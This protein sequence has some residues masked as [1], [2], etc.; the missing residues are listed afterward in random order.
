MPGCGAAAAHML[1]IDK[2]S[3]GLH[4]TISL[5]SLQEDRR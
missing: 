3:S 2:S 5:N 1:E 4:Q